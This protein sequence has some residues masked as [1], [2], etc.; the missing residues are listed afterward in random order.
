MGNIHKKKEHLQALLKTAGFLNKEAGSEKIKKMKL[1]AAQPEIGDQ[2]QNETESGCQGQYASADDAPSIDGVIEPAGDV[3]QGADDKAAASV[4]SET[5]TKVNNMHSCGTPSGTPSQIAKSAALAKKLEACCEA[6]I[7][8]QAAFNKVASYQLESN[9]VV[10]ATS[11]LNKVA[12]LNNVGSRAEF[13]ALASDIDVDFKKLASTNPLFNVAVENA[14]MRKMAAEVEALA[15][16]EGISPE[17]AADALDASIAEDPAAMQELQNEAEGE[18]LS[19]LAG[20]EQENA[21]MMDGLNEAA[22]QVSEILGEEVTP[23]DIAMA[24]EDVV[25]QAEEMGVEPEVLIQAAAQE[26]LQGD[27]VTPEDE[28]EAEAL[29]EEAAAQGIS[30]EELIQGLSEEVGGQEDGMEEAPVEEDPEEEVA[31]EQAMEKEACLRKLA[32]T[33]RG[34]NLI[35]ILSRI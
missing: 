33:R 35:K 8:K 3:V 32:S 10:T 23:D 34:A 25:A 2:M 22:V 13:E 17:E 12:S 4:M 11:V 6:E 21:A 7:R 18:A 9:E 28:A 16:A 30:P 26:M 24:V 31:E 29:I 14:L 27:E 15:E 5:G 19:D 1:E 20:A